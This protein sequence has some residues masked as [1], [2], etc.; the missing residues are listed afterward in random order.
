MVEVGDKNEWED[1]NNK[2][3]T[4]SLYQ[5]KELP[6]LLVLTSLNGQT[7]INNRLEGKAC[8]DLGNVKKLF[9]GN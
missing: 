1:A 5:V 4:H 8:L 7:H 2:F 6:T 3:R 9:G